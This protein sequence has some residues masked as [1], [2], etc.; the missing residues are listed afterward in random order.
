VKEASKATTQRAHFCKTYYQKLLVEE[1]TEV[2]IQRASSG[3]SN[4]KS[5]WEKR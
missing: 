1:A 2:T 3:R 5:F 4:T